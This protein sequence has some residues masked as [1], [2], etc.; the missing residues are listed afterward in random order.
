MLIGQA[1]DCLKR[2]TYIYDANVRFKDMLAAWK[3]GD[4]ETVKSAR[5]ALPPP[6][7]TLHARWRGRGGLGTQ[8]QGSSSTS[9]TVVQQACAL[10]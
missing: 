6:L 10:Q 3:A 8:Q 9:P 1:D 2:L 4:I 5:K 7:L